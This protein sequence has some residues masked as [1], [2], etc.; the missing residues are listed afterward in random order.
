MCKQCWQ[1]YGSPAV[2]TDLVKE[3]ARAID[4]VYKHS[5]VGGA[6]HVVISDWNLEGRFL[7]KVPDHFSDDVD[8]RRRERECLSLLR[9]CNQYERASAVALHNGFYK[10]SA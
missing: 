4:R 10:V 8:Q 2:E 5:S 9:E 7:D 6:L 1:E 3:T